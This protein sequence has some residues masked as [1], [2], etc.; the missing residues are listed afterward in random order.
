MKPDVILIP[1]HEDSPNIAARRRRL[2][3][4][5]EKLARAYEGIKLKESRVLK[6]ISIFR[7]TPMS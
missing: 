1:E 3:I 7:L 2:A 4:I 6:K 5:W